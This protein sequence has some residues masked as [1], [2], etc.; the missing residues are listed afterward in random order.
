MIDISVKGSSIG[1]EAAGTAERLLTEAAYGV[2]SLI[3]QIASA[4]PDIV[5][6]DRLMRIM[7]TSFTLKF[8]KAMDELLDHKGGDPS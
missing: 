4:A 7:I 1:I 2:R 8:T 6:K 3:N 5:D